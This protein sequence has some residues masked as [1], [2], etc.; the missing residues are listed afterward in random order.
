MGW[1][2]ERD[3]RPN[4]RRNLTNVKNT[5]IIFSSFIN[6][7][8]HDSLSSGGQ[9]FDSPRRLVIIAHGLPR[10]FAGRMDMSRHSQMKG[11]QE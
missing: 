6:C 3:T 2:E 5:P 8:E 1:R 4:L 9:T 11:D 7:P 10:Q